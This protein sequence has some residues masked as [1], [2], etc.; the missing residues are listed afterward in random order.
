MGVDGS[1]HCF[2]KSWCLDDPR[3]GSNDP[4]FGVKN[5]SSTSSICWGFW[6]CGRTQRHC[7]SLKRNQDPAP[8][9]HYGLWTAPPWSLHPLPSLNNNCLNLL[10]GNVMEAE[11]HS[12]KTR[13]CV[14][15]IPIG[16]CLVSGS[17]LRKGNEENRTLAL[18]T[19]GEFGLWCGHSKS[20][21]HLWKSFRER[22][23]GLL[24]ILKVTPSRVVGC[25]RERLLRKGVKEWNLILSLRHALAAPSGG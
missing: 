24:Y 4:S 18:G 23:P 9:L 12:P 22:R 14:A 25:S 11:A 8:R 19:E 6:C 10:F 15:R 21:A 17:T 2:S 16:P 5:A 7:Y 13:N 3:V 20:P 1:L